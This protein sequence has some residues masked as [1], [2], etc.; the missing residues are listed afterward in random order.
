L[1]APNPNRPAYELTRWDSPTPPSP[2]LLERWFQ[3]EKLAPETLTLTLGHQTEEFVLDQA[4]VR[5][6][7][8]GRCLCGL[9]GYGVVELGPGDAIEIGAGIRHD[10]QSLGTQPTQLLWA[11]RSN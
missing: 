8:E 2:Q 6:V 10:L 5:V 1:S 4:V 7:T 3:R 11:L 9:P